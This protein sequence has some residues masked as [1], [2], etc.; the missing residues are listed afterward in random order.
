MPRLDPSTSTEW[1]AD[2][3][4]DRLIGDWYL[5][6]RTGGHRTST[7]DL[8]TAW[9]AVHRCTE[10]P[11]RYLDLGCGVG[12]VLLMTSH[13]LRPPVVHG[14]EAQIQSVA[15]AR[16]SISELPTNECSFR[17]HHDDIRDIE[18]ND[19]LYDLVTGSPPYFP[20]DAG[21]LP[22]DP[23]KRDCRF[24]TRGGVE[25]YL[26]AAVRAMT[27]TARLYLVFQTRQTDR[28]IRAASRSELYLGGKAEFQKRTVLEQPFLTVFEFGRSPATS[29]HHVKYVVRDASGEI[30]PEYLRMRAELG[31]QAPEG[32]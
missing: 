16:R 7:D 13:K 17:V 9:Y 6:Q 4:R 14:V 12:S 31:V 32:I 28:L 8:I 24:D 10:R 20:I 27:Q 5:Y 22:G 30:T 19:G 29:P 2:A 11:K 1:P 25:A 3:R 21:S 18:F 26:E 15:M 23:Q